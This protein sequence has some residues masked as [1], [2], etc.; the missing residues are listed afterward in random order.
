M[1][2][3]AWRTYNPCT[4]TE[5]YLHK[6]N[7][8]S[9]AS[10]RPEILGRLG[11]AKETAEDPDFAIRNSKGVVFKYRKGYGMLKTAGLWLRLTEEEDSQGNYYVK[12]VYFTREIEEGEALCLR[13]VQEKA[14]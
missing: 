9:H 1:A 8:D 7:W 12:T 6:S 3:E 10:K 4:G 11:D 13:R 14:T 5:S 2:I